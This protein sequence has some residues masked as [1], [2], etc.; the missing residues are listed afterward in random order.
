MESRKAKVDFG[1]DQPVDHAQ[2]AVEYLD[3]ASLQDFNFSQADEN[4]NTFTID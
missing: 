1:S 3:F 2:V 4:G